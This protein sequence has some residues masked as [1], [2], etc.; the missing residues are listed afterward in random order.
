M[1]NINV[2]IFFKFKPKAYLVFECVLSVGKNPG[3]PILTSWAF[4]TIVH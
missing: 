4:F 2:Y 1:N 3:H